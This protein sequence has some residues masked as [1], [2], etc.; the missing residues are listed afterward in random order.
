MQRDY[1]KLAEL[2]I[3]NFIKKA[4]KMITIKKEKEIQW[5]EEVSLAM[6]IEDGLKKIHQFFLLCLNV[7]TKC[8]KQAQFFRYSK[9]K[10][11]TW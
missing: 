10:F 11:I 8:S 6:S 3:T 2:P 9:M 1:Q 5:M 7:R 4:T